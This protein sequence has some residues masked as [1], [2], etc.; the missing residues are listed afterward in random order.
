MELS[1][2]S[3]TSSD[4]ARSF[5]TEDE[6]RVYEPTFAKALD[7]PDA[8]VR[9]VSSRTYQQLLS[10]GD[11]LHVF[12][13][14][15]Y[16]DEKGNPTTVG[17]KI[18]QRHERTNE[19]QSMTDKRRS[20][21][22]RGGYNASVIS[23]TVTTK[24]Q[25]SPS[26]T[27][28]SS[29]VVSTTGASSSKL[30]TESPRG[31][32]VEPPKEMLSGN[33]ESVSQGELQ[34]VVPIQD[35]IPRLCL[36]IH[37]TTRELQTFLTTPGGRQQPFSCFILRDRS[38]SRT[39]PCYRL[40]ADDGGVFLLSA[41]R[42]KKSKSSNYLVSLMEDDLARDSPYYF[43][44]V[45]SNFIGTQFIIYDKGAKPDQGTSNARMELGAVLY[46]RNI[47]GTK[48]PR[49]MTALVPK[50]FP[51]GKI[52]QFQPTD[53]QDSILSKYKEGKNDES[54]VSLVN[55][56][57]KWNDQ[58]NAY[59][60]NFKGRVTEASVKNFQLVTENDPDRVVLQFGKVGKDRFNMDFGWPV[61]AFQAFAICLTSFDNKLACE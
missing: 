42:R 38:R 25:Y 4:H 50:V 7:N 2:K 59:C 45:R 13:N 17:P 1:K 53:Q 55:K 61:T 20:E 48:G 40:F 11:T 15:L 43:G 3:T 37:G 39:Y 47:L 24:P 35:P 36:P 22:I 30:T 56:S 14:S 46:E 34:E 10:A 12:G 57:P 21:R 52:S 16:G 49:K 33:E 18:V 6:R 23:N 29:S 26:N 27:N 51:N 8:R 54:L 31:T 32:E 58:L 19:K 41:R 28:T 44:K 60:L 9:P 5:D